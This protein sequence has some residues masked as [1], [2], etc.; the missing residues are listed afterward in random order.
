MK[1]TILALIIAFFL[2]S[3]PVCALATTVDLSK[4]SVQLDMVSP[5][6]TYISGAET[7]LSIDDGVATVECWVKGN[8]S[9]AT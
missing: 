9:K 6:L 3:I 7:V 4:D 1:K 2:I 5:R 8:V